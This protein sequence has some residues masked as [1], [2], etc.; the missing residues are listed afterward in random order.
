MDLSKMFTFLRRY[1]KESV[2]NAIVF[3]ASEQFSFLCGE[4]IRVNGG[5]VMT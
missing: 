1:F 2:A 3:L 4:T 5:K